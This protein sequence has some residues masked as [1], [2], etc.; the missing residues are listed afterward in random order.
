MDILDDILNDTMEGL[1]L[2]LVGKFFARR[3]YIY[4]V[5]KW[6]S[7]TWKTK[8]SVSISAMPKGLFL[9]TFVI[10]EDM[11]KVLTGGLWA[12]DSGF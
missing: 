3:P 11:L 5:W 7:D 8:G 12:F 10:L 6:A 9:F 1:K 2:S 4:Q